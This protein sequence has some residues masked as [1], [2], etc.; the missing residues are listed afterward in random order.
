M[1]LVKTIES[2]SNGQAYL[3]ENQTDDDSLTIFNVTIC[4]SDGMYKQGKFE[5][6]IDISDGYP[7]I[8]P[9][10]IRC[11][12]KV[13]HPNIDQIDE[14]SEG[15]I[16]LNLLDELWT[17]QLTLEDYVQGLLFI[18]YNPNVEDPLNPAFAGDEDQERMKYNIRRSMR[19]KDIEETEYDNV[20]PDGYESDDGETYEEDKFGNRDE[21]ADSD[22][23]DM[24]ED[25][26][27]ESIT[28]SSGNNN[29]FSVTT[30][31][32]EASPLPTI[33]E[34]DEVSS[35]AAIDEATGQREI[36]VSPTNKSIFNLVSVFARLVRFFRPSMSSGGVVP[37][38]PKLG[39]LI[40][41]SVLL[42]AVKTGLTIFRNPIIR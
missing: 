4:P 37:F 34:S 35:L 9:P 41:C 22:E 24:E 12:T 15:D 11:L 29:M 8:N 36:V 26:P 19:G 21:I 42:F 30:K 39:S 23:S 40:V 13:Y 31:F 10:R 20:L 27:E 7:E 38:H 1:S 6:E 25:A 33:N 32:D 14:Y 3:S 17:P 16:C 5:F 18:F 28:L 2:F